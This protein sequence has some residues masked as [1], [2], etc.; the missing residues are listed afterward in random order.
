MDLWCR[1]TLLSLLL[2]LSFSS[3]PAAAEPP[4]LALL[5]DTSGSIQAQDLGRVQTLTHNLLSS[6]PGGC[7]ITVFTFDDDAHLVLEKTSRIQQ[8]EMAIGSLRPGGRH[9]ALYDALFDASEYLEGQPDRPKAILLLSDGRNERGETNLE[10]G[11]DIARTRHIPVFTVGV[12]R[13]INRRVLQRIAQ[14]T[15]G[16]STDISSVTGQ[17]LAESIQRVL[18]APATSPK[19]AETPPRAA[20]EKKLDPP[21]PGRAPW[22][23]VLAALAGAL[24]CLLLLWALRKPRPRAAR[25]SPD[26][27]PTVLIQR[28]DPVEDLRT[29]QAPMPARTTDPTVRLVLKQGTLVVKEGQGAGQIFSVLP[30]RATLIGRNPKAEVP[31]NDAAVSHE[32]CRI[33]PENGGYRICDLKSTN[34]TSVNGILVQEQLLRDGDVIRI[35]GMSLEFRLPQVGR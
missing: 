19:T 20:P 22:L 4:L 31:V 8:I 3:T 13:Q 1:L 7:E 28:L 10:D 27:D 2:F 32:H 5:L 17:G 14:Q 30:V 15:G 16:T 12:G 6:L 18:T 34:G 24:A 26:T 23:P 9:T 21:P 29:V 33:I 25:P 35:G 11:L